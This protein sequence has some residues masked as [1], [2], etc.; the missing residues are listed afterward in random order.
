MNANKH[1][2]TVSRSVERHGQFC[3]LD[4]HL[5]VLQ[6]QGRTNVFFEQTQGHPCSEWIIH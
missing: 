4:T 1:T 5:L 6:T 2:D 3:F